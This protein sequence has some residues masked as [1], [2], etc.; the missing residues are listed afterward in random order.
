MDK[1]PSIK[2]LVLLIAWVA[3]LLSTLAGVY[4]Q[5]GVYPLA[6]QALAF[7]A[8]LVALIRRHG[9]ELRMP[10]PGWWV[11]GG[12]AAYAAL[13]LLGVVAAVDKA[14]ALS[15]VGQWASYL[16]VLGVTLAVVRSPRG[17]REGANFLLLLGAAMSLVG[18][19]FFWGESAF[20]PQPVMNSLF[21]NKNHFAG[22]LGLLL[23][24]ALALYMGASS[25][26]E[27]LA[28]GATTLLLGGSAFLTYS[29]GGWVSLLFGLAIVLW[30]ARSLPFRHL[31]GRMAILGVLLVADVALL[32]R[33]SF[34]YAWGTGSQAIVSLAEAAVGGSPQGTLAPRL[35]Y[36]Q[37]AARIMQDFPLLG[38]GLGSFPMVFS[39]YQVDPR[40]YSKYAH[41]FWLQSGAELGVMGLLA[42]LA[43]L[44]ALGWCCFRALRLTQGRPWHSERGYLTRPLVVGLV[45]GLAA[46]T[47]HNLVELDWYIPAIGILF[48]AEVGMLVSTLVS[49]A[50]VPHGQTSSERRERGALRG[51]GGIRMAAVV[52]AGLLLVG[53][54]VQGAQ[55]LLLGQGALLRSAGDEAQAAR[56]YQWAGRLNPLDANPSYELGDMFMSSYEDKGGEDALQ[57]GIAAARQAVEKVPENPAYRALLA[58]L[59]LDGSL[60]GKPMLEL[61]IQQMEAITARGR[62]FQ[63]PY[64]YLELG[65]VYLE[66]GRLNEAEDILSR[67]LQG[68]PQ[69]LESPQPQYGALSAQELSQVL[70]EAHLGLGNISFQRGDME[71]AGEHYREAI[72]LSPDNSPA[73]FNLGMAY[74]L[75]GMPQRAVEEL[76]TS[77][78]LGPKRA[79]TYYYAGLSYREL[80]RTQEAR[81]S[82][83]AAVQLAPA[84]AEVR[85]QLDLLANDKIP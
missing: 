67:L 9:N 63:A 84:N 31:L 73:H 26:R 11:V 3:L 50:N 68:F 44:G 36:W 76:Q 79:S 47:S 83:E 18:F 8:V 75:S 30:F 20:V 80:G 56:L 45:G 57:K 27:L 33:V 40:F 53:A 52:L 59:Y 1:R 74:Y 49:E 17:L 55:T 14:V 77:L 41:N 16:A 85:R 54:L 43:I 51:T 62:P 15:Q 66:Q 71:V 4:S 82:F 21:G 2:R 13:G 38:T 22:Y 65:K 19:Y 35:D 6:V 39:W 58:R 64:A 70:T 24:L 7:G 25:R 46:S 34:S 81:R 37:G 72:A 10:R 12:L 42:A 60:A 23:P 61:A 69:G 78:E 32:S 29:R 5:R 48:W 28:Y